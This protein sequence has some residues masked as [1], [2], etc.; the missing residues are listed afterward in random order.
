M[1]VRIVLTK[2]Y[3]KDLVFKGYLCTINSEVGTVSQPFYEVEFDSC[4]D[5]NDLFR[6]SK[7]DNLGYEFS[8]SNY[9]VI[10][11]GDDIIRIE[12]QDL[13]YRTSFN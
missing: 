6:G 12:T 4:F 1:N 7:K 2:D 9:V 8:E 3:S 13:F 10:V 11:S 5:A